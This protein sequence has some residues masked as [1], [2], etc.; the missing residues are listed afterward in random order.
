MVM[1]PSAQFQIGKNGIHDSTIATLGLLLEN[2]KQ[3]RISFLPS[4]GRT[5]A[6]IKQMAEEI[7]SKLSR[8]CY[9]KI[10]GFK[11]ILLRKGLGHDKKQDL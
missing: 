6:N 7:V 9:V 10:I 11:V 1:K 5:S 3:V 2:H 4:S 8:P